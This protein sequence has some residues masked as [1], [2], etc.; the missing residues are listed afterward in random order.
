MRLLI[1]IEEAIFYLEEILRETLGVLD[2]RTPSASNF[3]NWRYKV[4]QVLGVIFGFESKE[5]REFALKRFGEKSSGDTVRID[6]VKDIQQTVTIIRGYVV[7]LKR[8]ISVNKFSRDCFVAMWFDPMMEDIY[9]VG[10][11]K[12]LKDLGYN[13]IRVDKVEHNDRIDQKIFDLIRQSRFVVADISGHRGGVYYEAGFASGLGLP[14]IQSC[15]K[16]DFE[17]RHFDVFTINTIV[18]ERP[19]ELAIKIVERI[20]ETI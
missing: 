14:V 8:A 17:K 7:E 4:N 5:W 20:R 11:Y 16:E 9:Q 3:L 18:Y 15:R 13:P 2:C 1:P 10:I 6:L 19:S 12:P